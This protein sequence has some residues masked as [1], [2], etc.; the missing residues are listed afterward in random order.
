MPILAILPVSDKSEIA[1]PVIQTITVNMVNLL[2]RGCIG[3]YSVHI[4]WFDCVVPPNTSD[5]VKIIPVLFRIPLV[6]I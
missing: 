5:R 2:S 4:N 1:L 3:D 6:L